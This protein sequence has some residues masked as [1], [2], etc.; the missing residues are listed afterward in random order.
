MIQ[1]RALISGLAS[2]LAAPAIVRADG[3]MKVTGER[4]FFWKKSLPLLPDIRRGFATIFEANAAFESVMSPNG[5][6]YK[7]TWTYF[8]K[9]G[10]IYTDE[11]V[12][13][14]KREYPF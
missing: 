6:F 14:T 9:T 2:I 4:Y 8:G 5:R 12:S 10:N 13:F 11:V 3:L 7:G 1:R